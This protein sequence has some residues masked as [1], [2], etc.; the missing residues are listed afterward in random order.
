MEGEEIFG[1]YKRKANLTPKLKGDSHRCDRVN[2][3]HPCVNHTIVSSSLNIEKNVVD[4]IEKDVEVLEDPCEHGVWHIMLH[5]QCST[6]QKSTKHFCVTK[7]ITKST[8]IGVPTPIY[9]V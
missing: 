9:L 4:Q 8:S 6:L 5:F 3:S 7:I 1:S 2:F